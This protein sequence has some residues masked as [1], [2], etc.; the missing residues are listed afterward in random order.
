MTIPINIGLHV[1]INYWFGIAKYP[2]TWNSKP[3]PQ[4]RL[5]LLCKPFSQ[6]MACP[7]LPPAP[8]PKPHGRNG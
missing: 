7:L 8:E 1:K 6:A 4:Q 2:V 3:G 5:I